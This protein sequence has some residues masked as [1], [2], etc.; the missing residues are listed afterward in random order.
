[1]EVE[2]MKHKK[3][4]LMVNKKI[5]HDMKQDVDLGMMFQIL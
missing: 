4:H 5:M 3:K 1:M 2:D